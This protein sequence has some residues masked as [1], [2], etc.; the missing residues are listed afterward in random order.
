[1]QRDEPQSWRYTTESPGEG[2][3]GLEFDDSA[4]GEGEP[5]FGH[6]KKREKDEDDDGEPDPRVVR[7]PWDSEQIWLRREIEIDD[8][9]ELEQLEWILDYRGVYE[10]YLNQV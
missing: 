1:M 8:P 2:W 3:A 6:I 7:T 4:W 5:I 10:L 9:A